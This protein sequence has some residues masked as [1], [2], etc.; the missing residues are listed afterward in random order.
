[1]LVTTCG[2]CQ[3]R[4]RVT[5][6]QLNARQGQVRCGRCHSVFNGFQA[7]ERFPDDDTGGRLLAEQE[8]RARDTAEQEATEAAESFEA[9]PA[10]PVDAGDIP[11]LETVEDVQPA[12]APAAATAPPYSRL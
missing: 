6:Q 1:M 9:S 5:P 8:A 3:A 4:F 11:D 12:P 2:H 7:L 10:V